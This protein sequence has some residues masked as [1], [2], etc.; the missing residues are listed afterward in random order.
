MRSVSCASVKYQTPRVL[1][2]DSHYSR[3]RHSVYRQTVPLVPRPQPTPPPLL[4][5]NML[6]LSGVSIVLGLLGA[7]LW[8]QEV[9][10]ITNMTL[11]DVSGSARRPPPLVRT[12]A[13]RLTTR[14]SRG[15][16][17]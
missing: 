8:H 13:S 17:P 15:T 9:P 7:R 5:G 1:I 6:L 16:T 10:L 3:S 11:V 14:R 2:S 12:C 4:P